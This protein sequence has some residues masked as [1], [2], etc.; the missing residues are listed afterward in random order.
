LCNHPALVYEEAKEFA[1]GE[2]KSAYSFYPANYVPQSNF[3]DILQSSKLA[4]LD[5]LLAAVRRE[6][7]KIVVVSNYIQTLDMLAIYLNNKKYQYLRLDGQTP[8]SER[9]A[10]V[11]RF[12]ASYAS[13][14]FVF[15]LSAKAGGVSGTVTR[16]GFRPYAQ[17]QH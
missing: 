10:I 13:D 9:S 4:V 8:A 17:V 16:R 3:A 7:N 11:E 12:N 15:L 6:N 14:A 1:G 5:H 2:P